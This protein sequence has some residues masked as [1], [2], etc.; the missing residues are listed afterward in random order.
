MTYEFNDRI[1]SIEEPALDLHLQDSAQGLEAQKLFFENGALRSECYYRDGRLH[2]PSRFFTDSGALLSETWFWNG[3]RVGIARFFYSNG[4]LYATLRF[5]R[6][7]K[8]G[9]Q[10]YFYENQTIKTVEEYLDGALHGESI[11]YWPNGQM[12]RR[13]YFGYGRRIQ[14]DQFWDEKGRLLQ[15]ENHANIS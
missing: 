15:L 7:R 13:S 12:K 5:S 10:E 9:R 6:N 14:A 3:E 11:L 2:G 8:C 1:F 4:A